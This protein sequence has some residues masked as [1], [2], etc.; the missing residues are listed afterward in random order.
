[1]NNAKRMRELEKLFPAE[2]VLC[3]SEDGL[4]VALLNLQ[5]GDV[6]AHCFTAEEPSLVVDARF[7]EVSAQLNMKLDN[8]EE[9]SANIGHIVGE[10]QKRVNELNEQ[11]E[12][13]QKELENAEESIENMEKAETE[14]RRAEA[15]AAAHKVLEEIN[16][17]QAE[18]E[19]P[20]VDEKVC[21][22]VDKDIDEGEYD[23]CV[24]AK[25]D[26]CGAEKACA[27]VKAACMDAIRK[28]SEDMLSKKRKVN[29]WNEFGL[30]GGSGNNNPFDKLK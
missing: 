3:V 10:L 13:S 15:K 22:D 7:S 6:R 23:D 17:M 20:V 27:A 26:W 5:T 16:E 18:K 8:G 9:F 21:E 4:T 30:G 14:R 28:S 2:R 1:M 12:E 29:A 19:E 11:L 24:N 25:G